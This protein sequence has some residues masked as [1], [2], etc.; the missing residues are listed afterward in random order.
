MSGTAW[1]LTG[2]TQERSLPIEIQVGGRLWA[3]T[4][5]AKGKYI[6]SGDDEGVRVWRTDD[7][8]QMATM[9]TGTVNCLAASKDGKLIAVGT[10]TGKLVVLDSQTYATVFVHE[11]HHSLYGVDFSPTSM[12][13][14]TPSVS[15][16]AVVWDATTGKQAQILLHQFAVTAAK[17]SPLGDRIATATQHAVQVWD[18]DDGCLLVDI[19]VKV[20]PLFNTG[21]V[22][23][24]NS[25]LLVVSNGKIGKL[26]ATTGATVLEWPAPDIDQF[27]CVTLPT[28]DEFFAC[29]SRRAVILMDAS[30]HTQ[31]PTI[32]HAQK[33]SAIALSPDDRF[34]AI[35]GDGGKITVKSL[36]RIVVSDIPHRS[37]LHRIQYLLTGT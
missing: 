2:I 26:D 30:T 17:Y 27:T 19:N 37:S 20:V 36:P 35:G 32:R 11:T 7:G 23:Y 13:L 28:R 25:H 24:R 14:V 6:V 5:S 21:L 31:L 15:G 33:I 29:S 1:T 10:S 8:K 18:S 16:C 9:K 12:H 34:L 22:W 3:I 4:F